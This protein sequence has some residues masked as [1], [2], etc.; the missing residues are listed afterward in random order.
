MQVLSAVLMLR[1]KTMIKVFPDFFTGDDL[2]GLTETNISRLIE[3]LPGVDRATNYQR[4]FER[5]R[6]I[7]LPFAMTHPSGSARTEAKPGF[8]LKR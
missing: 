5:N 1:S 8:Q 3:S 6:L 4:K 7:D 2:F